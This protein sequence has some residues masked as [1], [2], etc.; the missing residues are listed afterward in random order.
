MATNSVLPDIDLSPYLGQWIVV[1][2]N[3][4]I[5]HNKALSRLSKH[6]E[7]CKQTPTVAKIPEEDTLIF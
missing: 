6:I 7:S 2:N 1:C 5:A 4:I 3:K